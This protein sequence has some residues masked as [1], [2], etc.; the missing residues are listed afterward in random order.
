MASKYR[1]QKQ[2]TKSGG[3]AN[4]K[5]RT[6]P[7]RRSQKHSLNKKLQLNSATEGR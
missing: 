5:S 2:A 3:K 4:I 6:A 7:Q 1:H